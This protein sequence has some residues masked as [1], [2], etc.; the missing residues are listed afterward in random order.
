MFSYEF[1]EIFQNSYLEKHLWTAT[2]AK[3]IFYVKF[4]PFVPNAP[5]LYPLKASE[6]HKD[7]CFQRVE[8]GCIEKSWEK[9]C[10]FLSNNLKNN[11]KNRYTNKHIQ[12]C[13]L[14]NFSCT[15][16]RTYICRYVFTYY[17]LEK[18]VHSD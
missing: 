10:S 1:H 18:I 3:D 17:R 5:F 11:L 6:N 4:N 7:F 2:S 8:K 15:Y 14:V 9:C 13:Y 16:I 12:S